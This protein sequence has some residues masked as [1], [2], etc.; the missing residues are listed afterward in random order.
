MGDAGTSVRDGEK[1]YDRTRIGWL[2]RFGDDGA[3]V[4]PAEGL[5]D[6]D[7]SG[8]HL[9]GVAAAAEADEHAFGADAVAGGECIVDVHHRPACAV[10][11]EEPRRRED[12]R[13]RAREVLR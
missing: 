3:V 6:V 12:G 10:R 9:V 11:F 7:E 1:W 5:V 2:P 8:L 13:G 4:A